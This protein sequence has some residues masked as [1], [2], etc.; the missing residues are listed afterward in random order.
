MLKSNSEYTVTLDDDPMVHRIIEKST[1]IRSVPFRSG[2]ELFSAIDGYASPV[3]AFID[4]HL[5]LDDCGLHI[6]PQLREKWPYCPIIIVTSDPTEGAV[7]EALAC[8]AD[9]FV[10]KPIR[11][12]ELLARLQA[13]LVDQ[14]QKEAKQSI[15]FADL[16]FDSAHRLLTGMRGQRYL[17]T[18]ETNL[19]LC[20]LQARGTIVLRDTLKLRCWGPLK[21]SDGALDRKIY[22]VRRAL[23]EI[24]GSATSIRTAYGVGFGLEVNEAS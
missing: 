20:L 6:I 10:A 13:R 5:G 17:S 21:V 22:E 19:L 2:R 9:D 12:R 24:G 14:A 16:T 18:T 15:H 3:A 1:G 8:G 7:A 11:S 23:E 4:I